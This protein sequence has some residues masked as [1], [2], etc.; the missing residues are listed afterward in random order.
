MQRFFVRVEAAAEFFHEVDGCEL[1]KK[2]RSRTSM[3]KGD[4][5]EGLIEKI[6][7]PN[8]GIMTVD[9][10]S[11]THLDVYKRQAEESW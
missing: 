3:K 9:A 7:F 4:V 1:K 8:K 6:E 5:V 11:Y 2:G 10:V